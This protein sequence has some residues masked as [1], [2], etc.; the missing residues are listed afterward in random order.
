MARSGGSRQH[1]RSTRQCHWHHGA[2]PARTVS[3]AS[4]ESLS[5]CVA[6]APSDALMLAVCPRHRGGRRR[7]GQHASRS[8]GGKA[9]PLAPLR[10]Q[11]ATSAAAYL[12][13]QR[14]D[15]NHEVAEREDKAR[16]DR[17]IA[18]ARHGPRARAA[19]PTVHGQHSPLPP[20][21]NLCVGTTALP[22][23]HMYHLGASWPV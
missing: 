11:P 23:A 21:S 16:R 17:D 1:S 5:P 13:K 3:S 18:D 10:A 2:Q 7:M 22:G 19:T 9:T 12:V 20:R 15:R 4:A 14:Q 6:L 8:R